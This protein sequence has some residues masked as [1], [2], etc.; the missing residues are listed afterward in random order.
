MPIIVTQDAVNF[1]RQHAGYSVAPGETQ[2]QGK[3][4]GAKALAKAEQWAK[5]EG[6]VAV[7]RYDD[8]VDA[9][10]VD[11]WEPDQQAEWHAESH[12]VEYCILYRP[13][14]EHG[15]DCKHAE[16]LASLSG[17]FDGGQQL[18]AR[19]RGRTGTGGPAMKVTAELSVCVDCYFYAA[20]GEFD[21]DIS[22]EREREITDA[23]DSSSS[24][25][26]CGNDDTNEFSWRPCQLCGTTL[27]G[28]RHS[29]VE[30]GK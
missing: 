7:W 28:S 15:A 17:I 20:N 18:P 30:L 3:T 11:T 12:Y 25:L 29:V 19:D 16:T 23:F 26:V 27:G 14:P 21:P 13:C 5:R 9:S 4:R 22:P 24:Q 8:D 10:F 2:A 1:F 6:L